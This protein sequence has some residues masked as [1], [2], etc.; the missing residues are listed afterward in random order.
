MAEMLEGPKDE[1]PEGVTAQAARFF[2]TFGL[3]TSAEALNH[4]GILFYSKQLIF[5]KPEARNA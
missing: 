5:W 3:N 4:P 2:R 1:S